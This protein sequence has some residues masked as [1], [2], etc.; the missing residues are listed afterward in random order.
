[1]VTKLCCVSDGMEGVVLYGLLKP[2]ETVTAKRY[3][4]Q[5][6]P[7]NDNLMEKKLSIASNR[8]KVILLQRPTLHWR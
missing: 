6:G 5:L 2:K 1:M 8:R 4:Q 3:Q 7:L